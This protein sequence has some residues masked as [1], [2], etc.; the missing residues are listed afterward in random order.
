VD[1][2]EKV[3]AI[4]Q[5]EFAPEQLVLDDSDGLSGYM[6]STRFRGLESLDRQRMIDKVL[7]SKDANLSKAELREILVISALTP[8]EH[9]LHAVD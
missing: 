6:I 7:R 4:L 9:A 8:E 5:A 3:T 2:K 1:V